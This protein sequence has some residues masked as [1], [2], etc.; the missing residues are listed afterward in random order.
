ALASGEYWRLF[1]V[2]LVH[3]PPSFGYIHLATNMYA[4]YLVVPIVEQ[5]YGWPRMLMMYLVAAAAAST[6]SFLFTPESSVGASGAIFGLF[7][8]VFAVSRTHHPM[9]DRRSRSLIRQVGMLIAINLVIGFSLG[10]TID[11]AAHIGGLV[12]GPWLG[13]LLVPSNTCGR[14]PGGKPGP[15]SVTL[16]LTWPSPGGPF[17]ERVSSQTWPPGEGAATRALAT[18]FPRIRSRAMRSAVSSTCVP[19]PFA[20]L[21]AITDSSTPRAA[22]P[23]LKRPAVS[24]S[25]AWASIDSGRSPAGPACSRSMAPSSATSRS[26]RRA[27]SAMACAALVASVPVAVPSDNAWAKPAITVRGVR[28][29]CRRFASSSVSRARV[30]ASSAFI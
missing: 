29:S 24:S 27:S 28:R 25:G 7:G 23:G 17:T 21:S 4:L 11:N 15:S 5:I 16:K 26:S 12:A 18:R 8:V 1:T 30:A 10:G 13:F 3:A 20:R 14:L 6:A 2:T 19:P 22:A 9:L